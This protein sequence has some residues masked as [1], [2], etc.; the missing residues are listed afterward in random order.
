MK[1]YSVFLVSNKPERYAEIQK[2]M[3]PEQLY[4]FDGSGAKNFSSLV[5]RCVERCP[6]EIVI[7]AGDKVY[8]KQQHI[9]QTLELINKGYGVAALH[10]YGLFGFKKELMRKIGMFDERYLGGGYED[11]DFT[12]RLILANIAIFITEDVEYRS[13][14]S[15]WDYS[16][17][18]NHWVTKWRHHWDKGPIP[19][20]PAFERTMPEEKYEYD[21]GP[22]VPTNFLPCQEHSF[23]NGYYATAQVGAFLKTPI[24]T[25]P[26]FDFYNK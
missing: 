25:I 15:S 20:I 2:S 17:S 4:Y 24:T 10:R 19:E 18:F 5:N 26:P 3:L 6:T 7:I 1:D 13:G 21:L 8:P 12:L 16:K 22:S 23:V 14:D 9:Q 11:Y